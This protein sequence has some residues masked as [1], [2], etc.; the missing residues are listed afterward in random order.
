MHYFEIVSGFPDESFGECVSMGINLFPGTNMFDLKKMNISFSGK[1]MNTDCA[2]PLPYMC[3]KPA[4]K[5]KIISI[6]MIS[7]D[8]LQFP[9]TKASL[10]QV[11]MIMTP[12]FI[13]E[14]RRAILPT[15]IYFG[16]RKL[17]NAITGKHNE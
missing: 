6:I 11:A 2:T 8:H 9:M 10:Q 7:E 3:T 12:S 13:L 14:M 1:W 16:V 4:R 5:L 17:V 15:I